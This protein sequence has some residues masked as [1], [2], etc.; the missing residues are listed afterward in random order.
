MKAEILRRRRQHKT[1]RH[2]VRFHEPAE[3][4]F[5]CRSVWFVHSLLDLEDQL[6]IDTVTNPQAPMQ[7]RPRHLAEVLTSLG[8]E[9]GAAP[10]QKC[11]DVRSAAPEP[12]LLRGRESGQPVSRSASWQAPPC[13]SVSLEVSRIAF[14]LRLQKLLYS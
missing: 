4:V 14:E 2:L 11:G 6:K 8:F 9:P 10:R 3:T 7:H 12:S 1:V 5:V 13:P